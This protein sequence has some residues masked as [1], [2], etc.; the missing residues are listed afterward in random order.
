MSHQHYPEVCPDHSPDA[1]LANLLAQ[2]PCV[3]TMEQANL[4]R[5][6]ARLLEA[7]DERWLEGF[8]AEHPGVI[9]PDDVAR[10]KAE[11]GPVPFATMFRKM[12]MSGTG[13]E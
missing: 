2:I 5:A 4:T 6:R 9:A 7:L 8:L 3:I 12:V 13:D 10:L 11:G 1:W